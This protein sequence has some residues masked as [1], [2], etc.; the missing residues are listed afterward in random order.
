MLLSIIIPVHNTEKYLASCIESVYEQGLPLNEFEVIL[1]NNA[2]T[3]NS[4]N[5]CRK[6]KETHSNVMLIHTDTPGVS[7]ARNLGMQQAQGYYIHFIDSDDKLLAEMYATYKSVALKNH[8][9]L[10][11]SGIDNYYESENRHLLQNP[12]ETCS[13][14]NKKSVCNCIRNMTPDKKIWLMNVIW[15]KWY[16]RSFLLDAKAKFDTSLKVG[17][18]FVFNC[19]VF[20]GLNS[21]TVISRAF[22]SYFH[23]STK[24]ALNQF[25]KGELERRRRME[26]EQKALYH[27][28]GINDKDKEIEI[29]NGELLFKHLYSVFREDCDVEPQEYIKSVMNDELMKDI[30]QFFDSNP[31]GYYN[32]LKFMTMHGNCSGFY[33]VLKAKYFLS[34]QNKKR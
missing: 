5:V 31:N 13:L 34:G 11:V 7:N 3:D 25:H 27:N 30:L 20:T 1:V 10:I 12:S 28:L 24:S 19:A 29:L 21:C 32:T 23:R 15:N 6:L 16:K 18:D 14:S 4:L 22:Y 8:P 2:S 33:F 26:K 17:E 9:D